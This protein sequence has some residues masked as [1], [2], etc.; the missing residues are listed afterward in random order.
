MSEQR[1]WRMTYWERSATIHTWHASA[2]VTSQVLMAQKK[3]ASIARLQRPIGRQPILRARHCYRR[4]R[5]F[6]RWLSTS[7]ESPV[8]HSGQTGPTAGH[9]LRE[10]GGRAIV[11]LYCSAT[12]LALF[13]PARPVILGEY[14][15]EGNLCKKSKRTV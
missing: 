10:H 5:G 8:R 15:Y 6:G 1:L 12:D 2:L 11:G 9:H 13:Y 3:Q 14:S 4:N 7:V